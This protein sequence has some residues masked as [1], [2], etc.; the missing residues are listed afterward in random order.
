MVFFMTKSV[1][2]TALADD[3]RDEPPDTTATTVMSMS[4]TLDQENIITRKG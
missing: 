4:P 3:K 1:M 2:P